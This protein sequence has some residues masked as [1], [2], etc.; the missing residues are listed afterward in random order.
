MKRKKGTLQIHTEDPSNSKTIY[1][2]SKEQVVTPKPEEFQYVGDYLIPSPE[3]FQCL[4][5][6]KGAIIYVG[7]PEKSDKA[8][9]D[10]NQSDNKSDE[11]AFQNENG[12][13]YT[14][15]PL[16]VEPN[17]HPFFRLSTPTPTPRAQEED[18]KLLSPK[19]G[20]ESDD[21]T[22]HNEN[23]ESFTYSSRAQDEDQKPIPPGC[24]S[25]M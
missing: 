17:N 12:E 9:D 19:A 23:G 14:Y 13:I 22:L 24:C 25:V 6:N 5:D 16:S 1:Y 10:K 20:Y 15:S 21:I 11:V 18:Q 2:D 4:G 7:S 3:G 8:S